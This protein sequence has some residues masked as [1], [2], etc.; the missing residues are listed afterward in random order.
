MKKIF[1]AAMILALMIP[2]ICGATEIK[3]TDYTGDFKFTYP[4]VKISN[5]F[6][7]NRINQKIRE[8][9]KELFDTVK[10]PDIST[11]AK[12]TYEIMCDDKNI[13]SIVL[14][15]M[16]YN[17]GAAHPLTFKRALN[18]DTRTGKPI[19]LENLP[20]I[21]SEY[22]KKDYTPEGITKKLKKY[23]RENNIMLYSDFKKLEKLPENFYF[24]KNFHLHFIFQQYDV[25]PYAVGIIDL[26]A[27][28]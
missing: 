4:T 8:E 23:A 20:K 12:M 15:E 3:S 14:T 6:V 26:D 17:Q 9:V 18:F 22:A 13:L 5:T 21:S 28:L 1:Y 24:D 19:K 7:E 27:T 25:A 11:A 16:M 10:Q 2:N